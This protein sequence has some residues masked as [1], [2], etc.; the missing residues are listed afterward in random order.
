MTDDKGPEAM[1][2]CVPAHDARWAHVVDLDS[3]PDFLTDEIGHFF[4]VYKD[5]EPNKSTST[6]GWGGRA[7]ARTVLTEAVDRFRT[8]GEPG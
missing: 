4:D 7:E 8:S 3:T 1:I 5:I 6:R 2:L